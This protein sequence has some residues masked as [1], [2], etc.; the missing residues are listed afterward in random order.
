M[1]VWR[2][3]PLCLMWCLWRERNARSFEDVET[4]VTELR[5]IVINTLYTWISAHHSLILASFVDFLY[6][7]SSYSFD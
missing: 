6:F 5:K 1:E 2:L 4:L 7:C 3:S